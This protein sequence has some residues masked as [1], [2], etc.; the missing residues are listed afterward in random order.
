[1][2]GVTDNKRAERLAEKALEHKGLVPLE[3]LL[4]ELVNIERLRALAREH[5]LSPKGFRVESAPARALAQVLVRDLQ[6][7]LLAD[8]AAEL[9]AATH[10][11]SESEPGRPRPATPAATPET[12]V[13]LDRLR[14]QQLATVS[15]QQKAE[16]RV[17]ELESRLAQQAQQLAR[18][19]GDL[20]AA[21]KRGAAPAPA[22]PD[23]DVM[24]ALHEA[25]AELEVLARSETDYRRR[26]AEQQTTMR[27]QSQRI[28][29]LEAMLPKDR[30]KRRAPPPPAAPAAERFRAP[31]FTAEFYRSLEGRD[32]RSV[33]AAFDA[34]F[35]FATAGYSYPGLEVKQ[36]EGVDLWSMRAGIKVRVYF[37]P[38]GDGH[39]D[40]LAMGDRE[41]QD[42]LLRRLRSSR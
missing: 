9:T 34:V 16:A 14:A 26:L 17:A 12:H 29:E 40:I 8:A 38:R 25:E 4:A 3:I 5:G 24:R 35:R 13:E 10:P 7:E 22:P 32:Q 27:T 15:A 30:R 31:Y 2:P 37:R 11:R 18:L 36:L 41:E 23:R 21:S 1:L 6:P 19:R 28:D 39:V 42:T 33:E 20:L